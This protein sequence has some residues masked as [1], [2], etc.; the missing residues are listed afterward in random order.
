LTRD[1][2]PSSAKNASGVSDNDESPDDN[3]RRSLLLGNQ[4]EDSRDGYFSAPSAPAFTAAFPALVVVREDTS[5]PVNG[6]V[7]ITYHR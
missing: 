1:S 7:H 3:D 4:L 5:F 6:R 2:A